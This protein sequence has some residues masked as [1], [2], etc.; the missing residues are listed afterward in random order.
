MSSILFIQISFAYKPSDNFRFEAYLCTPPL[1]F[2]RY[3]VDV[4]QCAAQFSLFL[5]IPS[6]SHLK[7]IDKCAE[8]IIW[9]IRK[10]I[11]I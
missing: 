9:L 11:R 8:W 10:C 2:V 5:N 1:S 7:C 6:T 3:V 4:A